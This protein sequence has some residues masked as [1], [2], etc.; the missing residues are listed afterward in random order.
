MA[1]PNISSRELVED[2]T[3]MVKRLKSEMD[4]KS[5]RISQVDKEINTLYHIIE[6]VKCSGPELMVIS[7][8][9]RTLLRERRDLK[10]EHIMIAT[11]LQGS[12][13]K[14]KDIRAVDADAQSRKD[15]YSAE[16]HKAFEQL[17]G[18]KKVTK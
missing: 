18:R 11:F 10:E 8:K 4:A 6:L 3:K 13:E 17:F 15:K 9:L 16:A 7:I 1:T 2:A 14:V 5:S 12:S